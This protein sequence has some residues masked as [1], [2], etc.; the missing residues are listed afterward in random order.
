MTE[1][2][3]SS[4]ESP[5]LT[6]APRSSPEGTTRAT[7]ACVI[8]AYNEEDTIAEVLTRP[9]EADP[10]AG[11][12]PRGHQQHRRRHLRR[13]PRV[14]RARTSTPYQDVTLP[15]RSLRPRH[16]R[17]PGQEGRRAELRLRPG[18]PTASTT[19]SA[20]T[21]TPR[22]PST[23]WRPRGGDPRRPPDRRDLRH[24]HASTTPAATGCTAKF[25]IA[26]QRAQFAA[27]QHGQPAARPQHGRPRRPV[28]H[29]LHAGAART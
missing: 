27:L 23:R 17:E 15:H 14:R 25:L 12:D 10:A 20:W 5:Y 11:R 16:R 19:S 1:L 18:L 2:L 9:A 21:A 22:W 26:G 13:R 29:L 24:L 3:E 28:L 7:I 6:I 8:P 4:R